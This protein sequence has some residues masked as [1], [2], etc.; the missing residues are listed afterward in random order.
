MHISSCLDPKVIWNPYLKETM[1]VPCG[2]CSA[3]LTA[4]SAR[5]VERLE[6]EK[7]CNNFAWFFTLTYDNEHLPLFHDCG[8]MLVDNDP[9]QCHWKL[10]SPMVDWYEEIYKI[11]KGTSD[12]VV[13]TKQFIRLSTDQFGGIPHLSSVDIQKFV[14]RIRN[15][16]S[17]EFKN[18]KKN[19][20]T[21][22]KFCPQLRYYIV[23]EI[24]P[25]TFRPHYHGI[26][27]FNSPWLAA[28]IAEFIRKGWQFG[29]IDQS[30]IEHSASSYVASYLNS[31][32]HLPVLY[33]TR[34]FRPFSLFSKHPALGSLVY[35]SSDFKQMF[36]T[37]SFE[38]IIWKE[39]KSLFDDVPIWRT[40]K[41]KL[42]PRL[43]FFD[44][45]DTAGLCRLYGSYAELVRKQPKLADSYLDW[46]HYVTTSKCVT[47]IDYITLLDSFKGQLEAKLQRWYCISRRVFFQS[48]AFGVTPDQYVE[49]IV[50]FYDSYKLKR[51]DD[52]YRFCEEYSKEH[53]VLD[54]AAVDPLFCR[55]LASKIV[56]S[57]QFIDKEFLENYDEC[58][59]QDLTPAE[60]WYLRSFGVDL[61]VLFASDLSVRQEYSNRLMFMNTE[62]FKVFKL[63]SDHHL[64]NSTKTKRKN[65]S[66]LSNKD[67]YYTLMNNGFF[68]YNDDGYVDMIEDSQESFNNIF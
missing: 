23:G 31:F 57:R 49:N 44:F 18:Y 43:S 28:N 36:L 41:D 11:G 9:R 45:I 19:E 65:D 50:K 20:K 54:L 33:Q 14:K 25:S 35:N 34:T 2:N 38:Q 48:S 37:R 60:E 39:K 32:T 47:F 55:R 27:F 46:R 40:I 5:M 1:V 3:C 53:D 16:I 59:E 7:Q 67:W 8:K 24:G 4:R 63:N 61:D 52:W 62:D 58:D 29:N 21:N 66:Q 56:G 64:N 26:F 22:E 10:G 12:C 17:I 13:S 68:D 15:Y 6:C 51:L 30:P 42:Y